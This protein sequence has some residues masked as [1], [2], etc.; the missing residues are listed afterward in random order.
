MDLLDLLSKEKKYRTV[1]TVTIQMVEP[2]AELVGQ[3]A[4]CL[5]L[6]SVIFNVVYWMKKTCDNLRR[7]PVSCHAKPP[8]ILTDQ[9]WPI[10]NSILKH[11]SLE[12]IL[13]LK[14]ACPSIQLQMWEEKERARVKFVQEVIE[15]QPKGW[16]CSSIQPHT[17]PT[18]ILPTPSL[19]QLKK[20]IDCRDWNG[21]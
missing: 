11:L 18:P 7:P 12:D 17:S 8:K 13:N 1:Q 2:V 4:A 14:N 3:L 9:Y 10:K 19:R 5:V 16:G 21:R 15:F 20:N 6:T